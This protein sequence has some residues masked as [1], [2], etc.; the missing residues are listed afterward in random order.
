MMRLPFLALFFSI[1]AGCA[2]TT[3]A[4]ATG[5]TAEPT[6]LPFVEDDYAR[7]LAEARAAHKPLFIDAWATWCHTCLSMRAFT[8]RDPK[9][10]AHAGEFVWASIDTENGANAAWVEQHPMRVWPTL[11]V[12]DPASGATVL[13][14]PSSATADE[15]VA[16]LDE[17]RRAMNEGGKT[18]DVSPAQA[19]ESHLDGLSAEKNDA[20]CVAVGDRELPAFKRGV[21]RATTLELLCLARTPPSEARRGPLDRAIERARAIISDMSDPMLADDRSDLFGAMVEALE[22]DGRATE[23]KQTAQLWS[24]YL[25]GE[26]A[27]APD[28]AA[29]AV[30]DAH[31]LEAYMA[32]GE[33]QRAI[34]MLEAS[35]KDFPKDYNPP[36]RL[37][38]A[39]VALKR[40][41]DAIAAI[42]RAL[43]LAYGPRTLRL[44]MTKAEAQSGRGDRAGAAATL[45]EA[46]VRAKG[47]D[48]PP[49]YKPWLTELDRRIRATETT[50]PL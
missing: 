35:A 13:E 7:A 18:R 39:Y 45:R 16:L 31:R 42:D 26:A 43:P 38:R 20:E 23:A 22:S 37:A 27:R 33:P 29:R 14:W 50:T 15:L 30:F 47:M 21:G 1:A 48:L 32:I 17:A 4:P 11:F 2:S 6:S 36:A 25:D 24:T 34:P 41:D 3:P 49:R 44:F 19:I 28:P 10:R 46:L 12:V 40:W 8:F 5:V 9:V